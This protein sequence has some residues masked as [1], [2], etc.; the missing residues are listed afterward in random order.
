M[1][2]PGGSA[3]V[4]QLL[5]LLVLLCCCPRGAVAAA[6]SRYGTA[7]GGYGEAAGRAVASPLD[8]VKLA[9]CNRNPKE[10]EKLGVDMAVVRRAQALLDGGLKIPASE[11]MDVTWAGVTNL[12]MAWPAYQFYL[13][14]GVGTSQVHQE[15]RR[16]VLSA[17]AA[18]MSADIDY[19]GEGLIQAAWIQLPLADC[20]NTRE[21]VEM[22]LALMRAGHPTDPVIGNWNAF[23][24]YGQQ[25]V[26]G[27]SYLNLIAV[28]ASGVPIMR[29]FYR[30]NRA[31]QAR[32]VALIPTFSPPGIVVVIVVVD[33]CAH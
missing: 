21:D 6:A 24:A 28:G 19:L 31:V 23:N 25:F 33:T 1:R 20:L 4:L 13:Q 11:R 8:T 22:C 27:V 17:F 14:Y 10:A 7:L 15:C 3:G 16:L 26:Q 12:P 2:G 9:L 32:G 18:G 30:M 29:V 5:V